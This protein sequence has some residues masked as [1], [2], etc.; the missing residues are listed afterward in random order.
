[1]SLKKIIKSVEEFVKEPFNF[2][3]LAF[4]VFLGVVIIYSGIGGELVTE[5]QKPESALKLYYFYLPTCPHCAQQRPIVA[6]IEKEI[7]DLA[8]VYIDV[9]NPKHLS[10]FQSMAKE[11]GLSSSSLGVPTMIIGKKALVG[12]HSKEQIL[13]ELKNYLNNSSYWNN[14]IKNGKTTK[15]ETVLDLPIVGKTDL[16]KL[17]LPVLAITLGLVDG[18][19]PCAMWVLVYMIGILLEVNDRRKFWIII[20][21]FLFASGVL[22]FLFM[23]AWLNAFLLLGYIRIITVLIGLFALGTGLLNLKEYFTTKGEVACKV[24]DEEGHKKTTSIIKKIIQ[25]PLTIG[26]IVSIIFLAFVINSIEFLCSSAIP[27]V[28][29]Q[30]LA[31]KNISELERYFYIFLYDIFYMIDDIIIFV[32]AGFAVAQGI[33]SKYAKLCKL[34]AGV[35]MTILG[36]IMLFAPQLLR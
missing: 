24:V 5:Q 33:G 10:L 27:A 8:V 2:Y 9:S 13:A 7:S 14:S 18:F 4:L 12:F 36:L 26:L 6:E 34:I 11:A 25:D 31:L 17:S 3:L 35:L 21:S 20:G 23:T 29:T 22:Y 15:L 19:N 28:F 30:I 16:T 32:M 1:M